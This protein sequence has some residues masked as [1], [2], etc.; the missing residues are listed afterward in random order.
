VPAVASAVKLKPET[1]EA[2]DTYVA[3]TEARIER[4]LA[5]D[6]GF[7][8]QDFF[9][10]P[11]NA[12]EKVLNGEMVVA[13]MHT[14]NGNGEAIQI[15][16]GIVHHWRGCVFLPGVTL[17]SYLHHATHP[18]DDDLGQP[19]ILDIRVLERTPDELKIYIKM[20]RNKFIDLTYNTEHHVIYR[21]HD[22]RRVSSQSKS[23]KIAELA[24]VGKMR[25]RE[26]P[27]GQDRGFMWRLNSYWR[28]EEVDGGLIIE[29]ESMLLSRDVPFAL[30]WMILPLINHSAQEMISNTL[31]KV[32]QKH[33]TG[34][35]VRSR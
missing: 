19:E 24:D 29:G 23:T 20:T 34:V 7:L 25:E 12:R 4:E 31:E 1:I 35:I 9:D 8:V 11:E 30:R 3:A 27:Q 22:T 17:E 15:P 5:S 13:E 2:W 18:S 32:R 21:R 16:N 6:K 14:T 33:T 10:Q 28:Y 26:K